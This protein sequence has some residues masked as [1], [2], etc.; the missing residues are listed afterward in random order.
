MHG[1]IEFAEPDSIRETVTIILRRKFVLIYCCLCF[2]GFISFLCRFILVYHALS[3]SA[4]A[5][6]ILNLRFCGIFSAAP[7]P[8]IDLVSSHNLTGGD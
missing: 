2:G 5:T 3:K 1:S 8:C 7:P 4:S 6:K